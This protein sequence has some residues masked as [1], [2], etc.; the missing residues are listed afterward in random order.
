MTVTIKKVARRA[1][2]SSST[3]SRVLSG[4]A[5]VRAETSRKVHK[6]MEEME[7]TPNM[8]AKSLVSKITN[9]ICILLPKLAE[10]SFSNL[11]Y[12]ELIR[13][14]TTQARRSGF[15]I[16]ISSGAGEKEELET[17]TRLLKGRR[18]DGVILL[19][20]RKEDAVIDFLKMLDF[21]FVLI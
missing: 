19:S 16:L 3:V 13:G 15:D 1:G 4:H 14:I 17:V 5:N 10:K 9:S 18:V 11:F 6:I 12:M 7:Y 2:V 8:I 21:P 20:S